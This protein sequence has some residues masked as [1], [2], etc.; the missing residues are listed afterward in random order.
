[1]K[2]VTVS[3]KSGEIELPETDPRIQAYNALKIAAE[4]IGRNNSASYQE[5]MIY[6]RGKLVKA[7]H[8]T[9]EHRAVCDAMP[10]VLSGE[11]TPEQAMATLH[12]YDTLKQRIN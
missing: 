4:R 7:Y 11:I 10:K 8:I 5:Q 12:E 9:P 2:T 3:T 1:M 6:R